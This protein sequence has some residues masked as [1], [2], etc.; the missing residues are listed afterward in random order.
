[1]VKRDRRQIKVGDLVLVPWGL[2]EPLT[3]RVIEI[4]GDPPA[5]VRV[6]LTFEEDDPMFLLL[7]PSLLTPAA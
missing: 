5:H 7:P 2:G 6:K 4:W 1:M 3:G